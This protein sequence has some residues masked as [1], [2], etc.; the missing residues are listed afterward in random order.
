MGKRLTEYA[1]TIRRHMKDAAT[2]PLKVAL[3]VCNE[4]APTWEADF[5]KQADGLKLTSWLAQYGGRGCGLPYYTRMHEALLVFDKQAADWMHHQLLVWLVGQTRD[6]E[7]LRTIHRALRFAFK[8]N[9]C[10]PLSVKAGKRIALPLLG[11]P[12]NKRATLE[13]KLAAET[14]AMR[15]RIRSLETLMRQHGIEVPPWVQVAN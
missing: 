5:R 4:L 11:R 12:L 1:E 9:G 10:Q 2:G 15:E 6:P 7:K 14:N 3:L 8:Q 13:Q